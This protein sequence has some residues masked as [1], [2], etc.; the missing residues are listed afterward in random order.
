M[1]GVGALEADGAE[2][3]TYIPIFERCVILLAE[4]FGPGELFHILV[5]AIPG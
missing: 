2:W 4:G 1:E 3:C 5:A